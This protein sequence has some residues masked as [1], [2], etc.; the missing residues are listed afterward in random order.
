MIV[1]LNPASVCVWRR[2][3]SGSVLSWLRGAETLFGGISRYLFF[4]VF[5]T[6]SVQSRIMYVY[7]IQN[8][9]DKDM[10]L[11]NVFHV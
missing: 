9:V 8:T 7:N 4:I 1:P 3:E 6:D 5:Y 10:Y 11:M 2:W